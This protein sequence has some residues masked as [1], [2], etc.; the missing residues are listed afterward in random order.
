M[1]IKK[2]FLEFRIYKS[3]LHN[4]V[5]WIFKDKLSLISAK[6]IFNKKL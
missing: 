2:E 5:S 4:P 3:L 1:N 6:T